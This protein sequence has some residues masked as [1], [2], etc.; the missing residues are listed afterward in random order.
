M[1]QMKIRTF[2]KL[3][4]LNKQMDYTRSPPP[5][6]DPLQ[7]QQDPLHLQLPRGF[8]ARAAIAGREKRATSPRMEE[9]HEVAGWGRVLPTNFGVGQACDEG[10]VT[11]L[12]QCPTFSA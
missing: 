4:G 7:T 2:V 9:G 8:A 12:S 3:T 5:P 11:C 6:C 1:A 10:A